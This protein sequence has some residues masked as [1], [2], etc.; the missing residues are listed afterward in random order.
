[1]PSTA[2]AQEQNGQERTDNVSMIG[3]AE[4]LAR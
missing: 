1:M 3:I 2:V 4:E